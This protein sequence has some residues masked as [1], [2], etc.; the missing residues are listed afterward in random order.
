MMAHS[1]MVMQTDSIRE[2]FVVMI[3]CVHSATAK[4]YGSETYNSLLK[5]SNGTASGPVPEPLENYEASDCP[6]LLEYIKINPNSRLEVGAY[7]RQFGIAHFPY[8]DGDCFELARFEAYHNHPMDSTIIDD[9][10]ARQQQK[11]QQL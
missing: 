8:A 10:I 4:V 3:E 5:T 9:Y 6:F 2:H 1:G 7:E 11:L